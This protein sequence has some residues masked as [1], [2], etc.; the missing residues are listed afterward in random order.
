M[1]PNWCIR[2][3]PMVSNSSFSGKSWP[4]CSLIFCRWARPTTTASLSLTARISANSS[5]SDSSTISPTISSKTSSIV[6][7]PVTA[8]YSSETS[9]RWLRV[10]RNCCNSSSRG[11]VLGT[12]HFG[13]STSRNERRFD[14]GSRSSV[15]RS[16][17]YKMPRNSSFEPL[18]TGIRVRPTS[19]T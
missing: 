10:L 3:P 12:F 2:N 19:V 5:L 11:I 4:S 13:R 17:T 15:K 16:F 1:C 8:L 6:T 14:F 18:Y 7:K 9:A